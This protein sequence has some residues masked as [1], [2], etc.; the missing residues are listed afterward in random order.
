MVR[1][2]GARQKI[3]NKLGNLPGL[4]QKVKRDQFNVNEKDSGEQ[5]KAKA[6]AY[7]IRLNEK[8]KLRYYYG[9]TEKQL[10]K[11]IKEARRRKGLTGFASR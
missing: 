2:L 8:Q 7:K 9:I 11:Y 5:K 6:S 10:I 4:T 3:V 1:Y